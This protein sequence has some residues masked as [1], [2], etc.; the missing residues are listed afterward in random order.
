MKLFIA[1]IFTALSAVLFP[2]RAYCAYEEGYIRS[3]TIEVELF[4]LKRAIKGTDRLSIKKGFEG[5]L[6]LLLNQGLHVDEITG[7]GVSLKYHE[8]QRPDGLKDLV[9]ELSGDSSVVTVR[10]H[11][12]F[13]DLEQARGEVR[14]GVAHV[15]N[16]VMGDDWVFLPASSAWYPAEEDRLAAFDVTVFAPDGFVTVMEG[17]LI[18]SKVEG[19]RKKDR[20][21][22]GAPLDGINIISG[23]YVVSGETYKGVDILTYFFKEDRELTGTYIEWTKKY[24]DLYRDIFPP[25][26]YKKF[27]VVES[28][29]PTGYGMPSFTLLGSMVLRLPFIPRTSLGHE[30]VHNW[31]GNSVFL[32]EGTGNWVEALTTCTAD[33]LY[34]LIEGTESAKNFR[35]SKLVGY[36]SYTSENEITLKEFSDLEEAASRVVGYN[37]GFFVFHMLERL[38]G[39]DTFYKSLRHFYNRW[40]F[41]RATWDDLK[42]AFEDVSGRRLDWFFD[43]WLTRSGGPVIYVDNLS[44]S[45]SADKSTVT[46]DINQKSPPYILDLDVVFGFKD[47]STVTKTVRIDGATKTFEFTFT[48]RPVYLDLDPDYHIFRRLLPEEIPPSVG[49]FLGGKEGLLV[50]PDDG[51][52]REVFEP[53]IKKLSEDYDKEVVKAGDIKGTEKERGPLFVFGDEGENPLARR[54]IKNLPQGVELGGESLTVYDRT[55]SLKDSVFVICT[56]DRSNPDTTLCLMAGKAGSV[57]MERTARRLPHLASK[58]YLIFRADGGLESGPLKGKKALRYY[59]DGGR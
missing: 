37:K 9:I 50:A 16:G 43:Q 48:K 49:S 26:P 12:R 19:G 6:R 54:I 36:T 33:H 52:A 44:I 31:W 11:G 10:F 18:E 13:K 56:K 17:N 53:V 28:A 58:G 4:P 32:E 34:A 2:S 7:S 22:S 47:H 29:L 8:T 27:A 35:F 57:D 38:L 42:G 5:G 46:F 1:F 3:H 14:R 39:R 20:W 55:Y 45:D 40:A 24:L 41:R 30:I 51:V 25:Y 59:I 15:D 21:K 23:R